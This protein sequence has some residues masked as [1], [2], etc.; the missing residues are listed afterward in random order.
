MK[1]VLPMT[2]LAAALLWTV[3]GWC[4]AHGMHNVPVLRRVKGHRAMSVQSEGAM[5]VQFFP[6]GAG[7][8]LA[9]SAAAGE[10]DLGEVSS[11]GMGEGP[12]VRI[13]NLTK[14]FAVQTAIGVRIG[15]GP[16]S[17][18]T[19]TLKGWLTAPVTP[20]SIYFD[21]VQLTS[22]PVS[23]DARAPVGVVTRHELK[24]LVPSQTTPSQRK[25][26]ALISVEA[27]LN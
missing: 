6:V 4:A 20:Y 10:L 27:V 25:L 15:T 23:L 17:G 7:N 3:P 24:I 14:A 11:A 26:M 8:S 16:P 18:A 13:R 1:S 12:T 5:T 22:Q 9:S 2:M 21:N 19:G